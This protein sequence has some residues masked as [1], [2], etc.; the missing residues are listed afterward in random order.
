MQSLS[1]RPFLSGSALYS[2]AS[3]GLPLMSTSSLLG[4]RHWLWPRQI[5]SIT[6]PPTR[7]T[8]EA[9]RELAAAART[10]KRDLLEPLRVSAISVQEVPMFGTIIKQNFW[11]KKQ[12]WWRSG[13]AKAFQESHKELSIILTADSQKS[14]PDWTA[15]ER[16]LCQRWLNDMGSS[17]ENVGKFLDLL[18]NGGVIL[19]AYMLYQWVL[20]YA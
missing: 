12:H 17:L 14:R 2:L 18:W 9:V 8:V 19:I 5:R 4:R 10:Q 13:Y 3:P 15:Q 6:N 7:S 11:E 20:C 1:S 16:E